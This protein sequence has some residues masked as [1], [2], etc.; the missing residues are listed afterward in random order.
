[1]TSQRKHLAKSRREQFAQGVKHSVRSCRVYLSQAL[2]K[3]GFV[4]CADLIERNFAVFSL[5]RDIN[6][7][8]PTAADGR[9]RGNNRSG[10]GAIQF[11]RRDN[12]TGTSLACLRAGGRIQL[13]EENAESFCHHSHSLRSNSLLT[14]RRAASSSRERRGSRK[15]L[16]QFARALRRGRSTKPSR[17]DWSSKPYGQRFKTNSSD[18]VFMG[19]WLPKGAD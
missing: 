8:G 3:A 12:N 11:I 6:P 4:H 18:V 1:M 16:L 10:D 17:E 15:A 14:R 5:E 7:G 19:I 13:D 2:K 9:E